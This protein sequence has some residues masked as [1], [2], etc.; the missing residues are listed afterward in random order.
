MS[1]FYIA[2]RIQ[3]IYYAILHRALYMTN[4]IICMHGMYWHQTIYF[5]QKAVNIEK[6]IWWQNKEIDR[7]NHKIK[8]VGRTV[9][10]M[11]SPCNNPLLFLLQTVTEMCLQYL[12][13]CVMAFCSSKKV[14]IYKYAFLSTCSMTI[15]CVI[16]FE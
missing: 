14:S 9:L 1:Q 3:L 15:C 5:L 7:H 2:L 16:V 10:F 8:I 4:F 12:L 13:Q 11:F 6:H